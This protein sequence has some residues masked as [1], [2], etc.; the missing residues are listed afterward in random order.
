MPAFVIWCVAGLL[1]AGVELLTG[2]FYVLMVALGVFAGAA[3]AWLG[4]S[5]EMQFIVA[6]AVCIIAIVVLRLSG[7]GHLNRDHRD[8]STDA[9]QNLDIGRPVQVPTPHWRDGHAR[10][11]YRGTQWDA[12]L[13]PGASEQAGQFYI[14]EVR[15][16]RLTLSDQPS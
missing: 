8:S 4:S 5:S 13:A 15:G 6:A 2:T 11:Q 10:V 1:L 7:L 3:A 14:R 9:A 12:V 16:T